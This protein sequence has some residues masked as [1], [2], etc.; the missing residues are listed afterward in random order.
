MTDT[1]AQGRKKSNF[2]AQTSVLAG[3]FFDF[4]VDRVN[5]KISFADLLPELGAT[6]TI[7]QDGAVT[8][9]PVLDKQGSVNNIRN[10]EAGSGIT[11]EVS[12]ENGIT[13]KHNFTFNSIGAPLTPDSTAVS[14]IIKSLVAG[15]G[16]SLVQADETIT[17]NATGVTAPT[18]TIV[19]N[20]EAD[21]PIQDS[22]TITLTPG[23]TY[24]IG[25]SFSTGKRLISSS[26]TQ[27][28]VFTANNLF[29]SV[30]TYTGTGDMFT[31]TNANFTIKEITLDSQNAN[32]TFNH[33]GA[34]NTFNAREVTVLNSPKWGT[35]DVAGTFHRDCA[36]IN[37]DDGISL[38]GSTW[39]IFNISGLS[40]ISTQ[41]TFK[42]VDFGTTIIPNIE[43][44]NANAAGP[45]GSTALDG[46]ASNGNVPANN[47][48]MVQNCN[49]SGVTNA[50]VGITP[51]DFRW[52]FEANAGIRDS[53]PDARVSL[54]G[55]VT[56]TVIA[57]V[58]T[59]VKVAGTWVIRDQSH[60]TGDTTGRITYI[61]ERDFTGPIDIPIDA[62]MASGGAKDVTAYAVI[63]GT[64]DGNT[65]RLRLT[66]SSSQADSVTLVS[67]RTFTTNDFV[68]VF[69]E[70]NT[71]AVNI[72]VTNAENRVN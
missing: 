30:V 48:A 21:F 49:F 23:I 22:T 26:S 36:A 4:F 70:N 55:N 62:M 7:V 67:Q 8:G 31:I 32:Q 1:N 27:G 69:V 53:R 10:L 16:V 19:I 18:D 57:A 37:V 3:A 41:A 38:V 43:I 56:A 51:D 40:F 2:P 12:P 14:P 11:A 52:S 47:L 29:G 9:T 45:A 63:N 24:K 66:P 5:Y 50:L 54:I 71:D 46:L 20:V 6:G 72:T 13:L 58:N 15:T 64:I 60:F 33:T 44:I 39:V 68:E 65:P 61:G 17:V 28:V 42:L 25:A 59:P 35:F 34:G